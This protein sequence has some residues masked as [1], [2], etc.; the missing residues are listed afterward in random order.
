[1]R[2]KSANGNSHDGQLETCCTRRCTRHIPVLLVLAGGDD[3]VRCT[4]RG[5]LQNAL[6]RIV[7]RSNNLDLDIMSSTTWR[8]SRVQACSPMLASYNDSMLLTS[9]ELF[10][11]MTLAFQGSSAFETDGPLA[12]VLDVPGLDRCSQITTR[13]LLYLNLLGLTT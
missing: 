13:Y 1:M 4:M 2:R 12:L 8:S 11:L 6:F 10:A 3:G 5:K 9:W 7:L